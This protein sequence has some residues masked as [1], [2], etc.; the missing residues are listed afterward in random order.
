MDVG[1]TPAGGRDFDELGAGAHFV[2]RAAAAVAH[3]GAQAA[4]HLID[5]LGERA[6]V[7]DHAFD[8]FRNELVDVA[9]VVVLEVAVGGTLAHGTEGAHAAVGLV[10]A[11]LVEDDFTRGFVRTG[12]HAAH[13]DLSLIHI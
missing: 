3:G 4:D 5:D 12:E 9:L 8:A 13:H 1:F 6:L 10:G 7:R 11:A 2:D